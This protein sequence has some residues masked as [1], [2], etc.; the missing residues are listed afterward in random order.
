MET[1]SLQ[2]FFEGNCE[3]LVTI[4]FYIDAKIYGKAVKGTKENVN[5]D[6]GFNNTSKHL[7]LNNVK[8]LL[9]K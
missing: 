4:I 6:T 1:V 2:M 8:I 5:Q 3:N 7:M 9:F